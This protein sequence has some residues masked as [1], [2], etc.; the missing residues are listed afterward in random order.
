MTYQDFEMK[1]LIVASTKENAKEML[2][3]KFIGSVDQLKKEL[4]KIAI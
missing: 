1:Y 2:L 3:G 4:K